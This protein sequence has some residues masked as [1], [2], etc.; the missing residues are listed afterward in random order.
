MIP[1]ERGSTAYVENYLILL[2][3][4]D[5]KEAARYETVYRADVACRTE[6][7]DTKYADVWNSLVTQ[8]GR[9]LR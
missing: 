5:P 7:L 8:F 3:K 1:W 9:Y 6:R 2:N 4:V